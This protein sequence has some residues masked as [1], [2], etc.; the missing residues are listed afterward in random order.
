MGK[1]TVL[2]VDDELDFLKLMGTRVQNWGYDVIQASSGKEGVDAVKGKSPDVVVLDYMMPEMDGVD[3]L[4]EI[5]RIDKKVPVIMFTAY[6]DLKSMEDTEKLGVSSY[7]P[8]LS[9]YTD[10][11][12]TLKANIEMIEKR[13][14][15]K[16]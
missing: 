7:I 4:K 16:D 13:L 12:A 1:L 2:I 9:N 8:K 10:T 14:E 15:K 3:T 11:L 5:R 6:P